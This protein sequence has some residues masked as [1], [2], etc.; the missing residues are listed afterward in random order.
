MNTIQQ[1]KRVG[2][3]GAAQQLYRDGQGHESNPYQFGTDDGLSFDM[4]MH[5]LQCNE[6]KELMGDTSCL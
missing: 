3:V 1:I 4:E 2:P 6:L 5:R